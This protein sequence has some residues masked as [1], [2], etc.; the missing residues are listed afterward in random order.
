MVEGISIVGMACRYPDARTPGELWE[1]ILARRRAFRPI[2]PERLRME[3]YLNGPGDPDGLYP[4][5][6]ALLEGY[7]FDRVRFRVAGRTYRATDLAHWLALDVAALALADAGFPDAEGLPRE[8]T[9]ALVGN[10]LTSEFT[11]ANTLRLRWPYVRRVVS[12]TLAAEGW[13]Q[14]KI[15]E[16]LGRLEAAYKAPFP[17]PMEESLAGGLANTIAGR[18]CNHFD[19]HGGGYT[20]DGACASSLLAVAN[21]CSAL[22]AGDLDVVLA[23]G[24]DLSLDPFELVGFAR[25]QALAP[26]DMRVFDARSSGFLPGEGCGFAVLMRESDALR[27]GCRSYG[28]I[29][30]W[31]ISSDGHG[32]IS[33]PEAE[34]QKLALRRAYKK[35]GFGIDTV[36]YFEGHGTGTYVG[37]ATELAAL[38]SALREAGATQASPVG[39]VKA[40][41]GHTKAAAGVAGLIKATLAV[42]SQILPPNTA[43]EEPHPDIAGADAPLRTL[44]H[45]EP[46]PAG[47]PVRA[48]VS[49]FGFGGINVHVVLEGSPAVRRRVLLARE[50]EV[51]S[52]WQDAELLLVAARDSASL[53]VELER[54]AEILPRLSRSELTDL[55][56]E[57]RRRLGDG[58]A[59][60]AVVAARPGEAVERLRRILGWLKD[61]ET[62]RLEPRHGAFLGV[63]ARGRRVGFLFPGQGSPSHLDGGL[64]R[65]RFEALE[66]VYETAGL[67]PAADPVDTAVAQPAI[68]T[69]S[70][71]S[72][73]LLDRLGVRA[74]VAVGHSLGEI[75]ALHWGGALDMDAALRLAAVRGRIMADLGEGNGAMASLGA[76]PETVAELLADGAVIAARNSPE[77]TVV[78]GHAAAV[79][80]VMER[81]RDRGLSTHRLRV[82]HAFHS[83]LVEAVAPRLAAELADL[84]FRTLS[85][86]VSSTVTG[87]PLSPDADLGGLLRDQITAPVRFTDALAA[88]RDVDLWIEVGPGRALSELTAETLARPVIP[89]DAGGPSIA[90]LLQAAGAAFAAGQAIDPS[91]LF[92][93]RFTRPFDLDRPLRFLAN[94]CETVAAFTGKVTTRMPEL[95]GAMAALAPSPR[96]SWGRP[97]AE[98]PVTE[99]AA[100]EAPSRG[101]RDVV[102]QLVAAR[103][104]LPP[105]AVRDD[106]RLLS[107]LHLNSISVGQLVVEAARR[108]GLRPPAAPTDFA[109]ATV[110]QVAQALED[111][112]ALGA[113]SAPAETAP[114]GVDSWVRPFTVEWIPRALSGS[115]DAGGER[116]WTV[117]APPDHPL[118]EVLAGRLEGRGVL[119]CLPPDTDERHAGLFVDAARAVIAAPRP[120]RFVLVQPDGVG[121]GFARTLHLEMPDVAVR[122]VTA[123]LDRAEAAEWIVAEAA[124]SQSGYA[125]CRYTADGRREVPVMRLLPASEPGPL[126]LGKEDVLLVTGGGKGIAAECALD[127]AR[128]AGVKLALLGRSRPEADAELAANLER[129]RAAGVDALYVSADVTD[130]E[131]VLEAVTR[132]S[133]ELGPVTAVLHGA[134]ANQPRSLASLDEEA[135]RRTLAPKAA[136]LRNV[137]AAVDPDRLRLLVTFG[138][139]IARTGLKGEADYAVANEWLARAT[140]RFSA[141]HPGCR[142]LTLEWSV[143]AGVGMG[144]KLGTLESLMA[145]GITPIPPET[146]VRVTREL[147]SRQL[148][149]TTLVVTGRF[150]DTP[151]LEVERPE[152][153][154]LRYLE[155]SRVFVPGVELVVDSEV[156]A[157]TDPHLADHVFRGEPLF[158]AVLGMEAMAQAAMAVAGADSLPVFE[159]AVFQRPVAVPPGRSTTIRVAALVREPG[160]VEVVLRD[161]S[162]GF[163]ADHFRLLCRFGGGA[164]AVDA[165][166]RL[167]ADFQEDGTVAL[168]PRLDLYGS[169]LFHQGR[170]RRVTG[171]RQLSATE[172]L[173]NISP[174]GSTAWFGRYLPDR[175]VLGDPGARDAAIHGIQACIPHATLLPT[176]V[177]RVVTFGIASGDA[178][179]LAARERS[180]N[181]DDFVYDLELLTVDGRLCERWEGLRLRAV[182]RIAPPASWTAALL[183]PYVE[184][185][186][187]EILPGSHLRVSVENGNGSPV[188]HRPDGKPEP[189]DG[190]HVSRSHAGALTLAVTGEGRLGCD[191]EPVAERTE[192]VWQ[193]LLG[194]ERYRLAE[195]IAHERGES[196]HGA[197]TRVWA[198]AESLV[199]AGVPQGAP[200]T[201]ER[202]G[203]DGWLLLRSGELTIGTWLAPFREL[204]GEAALAVLV[205]SVH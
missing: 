37:D 164:E 90:G 3:D 80:K 145:Q 99:A 142:C 6:A 54:L 149:A 11:R 189:A 1:N 120:A 72:L 51:L 69:H 147:I 159:N 91:I 115:P 46:W 144:E 16:I 18:I 193:G 17:E 28:V 20:L 43:C 183:G 132:I 57:L 8:A 85:R 21:A 138:S 191:L 200:L 135:F 86:P 96:A 12:G 81:A 192:E 163:A 196:P 188:L 204:S 87:G 52:S 168:D 70:L 95:L 71:A 31:G 74:A 63:G 112:T 36:G 155:K 136:G 103:A 197:A 150:G 124:A 9:G 61:G 160:L 66:A 15:D 156:S 179:L 2:P 100:A 55:A 10:T 176:G 113:E 56:A 205:E 129:M 134:G 154:L 82:S 102:R 41:I 203:D 92:D 111:Q 19:L 169:V 125:E 13:E 166:P 152:L 116:A 93:G 68:L 178:H 127:L 121:G 162:T 58:P 128:A 180:R 119:L 137:L 182:D 177:D 89:L 187:Q 108:L 4:I 48:G 78:S 26:D 173:A 79:E 185:R 184:R 170:F 107:D 126:P 199:K 39:S 73:W 42:H 131:A 181:G 148:P 40:N 59:R 123:P 88:A 34:G 77:R 171:Y 194:A 161:A 50:R 140:E 190:S 44:D 175:L 105:D 60:A 35:A 97:P 30:G 157:D 45:G 195:L 198:A 165:A 62:L 114:A 202:S 53:A 133:D 75:A 49:S 7:E 84:P 25:V 167:L 32:G 117:I 98:E 67:D 141:E 139:V 122:V 38:T 65:R 33:R 47:K 76:S 94:P 24:V 104:E 83:P 23:G 201:L 110:A 151:T 118:A 146:G 174:D 5:E 101:A 14:G 158:A 153:P 29:R 143:W 109:R 130:A 186:L 27:L 22:A 106:S 64:F 172:C